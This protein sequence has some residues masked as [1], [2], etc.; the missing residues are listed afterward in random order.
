MPFTFRHPLLLTALFSCGGLFAVPASASSADAGRTL[1]IES[2]AR[3]HDVTPRKLREG[4]Q[5]T[6]PPSF[7]W[8][9]NNHPEYLDGVALRAP[10]GMMQISLT[11]KNLEDLKAYLKMFP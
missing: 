1:A 11:A 6:K 3:C 8:I 7:A 4:E 2:C 9:A 10:H 5:E